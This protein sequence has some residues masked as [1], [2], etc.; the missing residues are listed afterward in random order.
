MSNFFH[1]LQWNTDFFFPEGQRHPNVSES[2]YFLRDERNVS[3]RDD[4]LLIQ[5]SLLPEPTF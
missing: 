5:Y 1:L 2:I 4:F 3:M